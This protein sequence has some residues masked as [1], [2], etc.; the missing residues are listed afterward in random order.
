MKI[1]LAKKKGVSKIALFSS[2][3]VIT[4]V[5][6]YLRHRNRP[7]W[8]TRINHFSVESCFLVTKFLCDLIK[9]PINGNL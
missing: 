6:E 3:F 7:V 1:M 8:L 9:E 5:D 4:K 2:N